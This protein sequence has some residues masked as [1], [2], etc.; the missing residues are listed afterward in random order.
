MVSPSYW[1]CRIESREKRRRYE[2]SDRAKEKRI[3]RDRR[4]KAGPKGQASLLRYY[5][6]P[7]RRR[8]QLRR[9]I[10]DRTERM[11]NIEKELTR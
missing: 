4:Y 7:A 11:T 3:P 8:N 10:R 1:R 6:S 5:E 9:T 2:R